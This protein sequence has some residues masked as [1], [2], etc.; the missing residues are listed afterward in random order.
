MIQLRRLDPKNADALAAEIVSKSSGVFL[1]VT[2]VVKSLLDGLTNRDRISDLQKR[3]QLLPSDLEELYKH[4]LFKH[5]SP[6]YYEQSSQILRI[7][8]AATFIGEHHT[9]DALELI[10]LVFADE[11]DE[12]LPLTAEVRPLT[13]EDLLLR[14]NDTTDRLKSRCAGLLEVSGETSDPFDLKVNFL[15]RTVQDFLKKPDIWDLVMSRAGTTFDPDERLLKSY[16]LQLK[17]VMMSSEGDDFRDVSD[18]VLTALKYGRRSR[19]FSLQSNEELLDE[20][21]KTATYHWTSV[22]R[23]T[24][25]G[26]KTIDKRKNGLHWAGELSVKTR[27]GPESTIPHDD[28]LSLTIEYGLLEYVE[29]KLDHNSLLLEQKAGR[30]FLDYLVS[31][32]VECPPPP[33]LASLLLW[34]GADPN[35]EFNGETMWQRTIIH[36]CRLSTTD[37][38]K[39]MPWKSIFRILLDA[40]ADPNALARG[41]KKPQPRKT[42]HASAPSARLQLATPLSVVSEVA[43]SS[44]APFPDKELELR[45]RSSGAR[46]INTW[47]DIKNE[48]ILDDKAILQATVD[49]YLSGKKTKRKPTIGDE[50]EEMQSI[51]FNSSAEDDST[52]GDLTDDDEPALEMPASRVTVPKEHNRDNILH[53]KSRNFRSVP[54]GSQGNTTTS[55]AGADGVETKSKRNSFLAWM[56][57]QGW[58]RTSSR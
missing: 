30:P 11:E 31:K 28:F 4:M 43:K 52:E 22:P 1:W 54:H 3:L 41:V 57:G 56:K 19:D 29:A 21:D 18:L 5:I 20:L 25:V 39:N 23:K 15:H 34:Y 9:R 12:N 24:V 44:A 58:Q 47:M 32:T 27:D 26:A 37:R 17:C 53:S 45:L 51:S 40:G 13:D 8:R 16:I 2:L 42:Y 33:E 7:F 55:V 48:S 46:C 14:C 49:D 50:R 6:F 10:T 36:I 35:H 38:E